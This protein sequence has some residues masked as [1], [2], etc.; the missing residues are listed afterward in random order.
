MFRKTLIAVAAAAAVFV[1]PAERVAADSGDFAAGVVTGILGTIIVNQGNKNRPKATPNNTRTTVVTSESPQRTANRRTQTAL[2]Y[3]GFNAGAADG[4]FGAKTASAVRGYQSFMAFPVV[5]KLTAF[6]HQVLMS[7]YNRG[8]VGDFETV[9]LISNNPLGVRALLLDT[10]DRMMGVNN[11]TV[12]AGVS[13]GGANTPNTGGGNTGGG[14]TG[15]GNTVVI[16]ASEIPDTVITPASDDTPPAGGILPL[17][18]IPTN[19]VDVAAY[20]SGITADTPKITPASMGEPGDAMVQLFCEARAQAMSTSTTLIAGVEG[21]PPAQIVAQCEQLGPVMQP[22]V[23]SMATKD[24]SSVL[25]D[26]NA[27]VTGSGADPAQLASTAEICLG[28]GY[29]LAKMD[30]AAGS[31]LLLAA[32]GQSGYGEL[33]GHHLHAGFGIGTN[34]DRAMDW[35]VWTTDELATGASPVF[36]DSERTAVLD[37]AVFQ[38]N[39][40]APSSA[41]KSSSS[42]GKAPAN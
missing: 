25:T 39:G 41:A 27:F 30:V 3:F 29:D 15:G 18:P 20:C 12:T 35:L 5:G 2:N 37:E 23:A 17:I 32:M 28:T 13:N 7:A 40:G 14:N 38:M 8:Q 1:M 22:Y 10:R 36:G 6:E 11:N 26:V 24:R 19:K 21:V 9:Q 4:L 42:K 34:T 16:S 33:L 31:A